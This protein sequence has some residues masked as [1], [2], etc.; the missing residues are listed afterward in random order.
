[1]G[2]IIL[3]RHGET[4]ANRLRRFAE[5]GDIPL[6]A[7]GRRQ[8]EDLAL[9]LAREFRP[10]L[11]FSSAFLRARQTSEII[12]G[13]LN[14]E[15]E[16][17]AGIHERDFGC[18]HGHPYERMGEMMLADVTYD[19]AKPWTWTPP[20]GEHTDDVRRRSIAALDAMRVRHSGEILVVCHGAVIQAI[21]GHI[22]GRWS[23]SSVPPN[24]GFVVVE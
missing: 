20:Q 23:E 13:V 19:P 4:E 6:N 12:G 14:L 8:A 2:R 9:R 24:C 11:L 15:T 10:E 5:S 22:T 1:M 21:C 7:L 16:V 18:L 17:I 3:V